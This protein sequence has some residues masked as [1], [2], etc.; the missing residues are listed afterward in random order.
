M[1]AADTPSAGTVRDSELLAILLACGCEIANPPQD[2][3]SVL[4]IWIQKSEA[5]R[6]AYR[7]LAKRL[8]KAWGS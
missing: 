6:A 8:L 5:V 2:R 1:M 3:I 7:R 4:E